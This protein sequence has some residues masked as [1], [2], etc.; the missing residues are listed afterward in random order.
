MSGVTKLEK[1]GGECSKRVSC[2]DNGASLTD[3]HTTVTHTD[4]QTYYRALRRR[5]CK[6]CIFLSSQKWLFPFVRDKSRGDSCKLRSKSTS[7][8]K[9]KRSRQ[10]AAQTQPRKKGIL[11]APIVVV[12]KYCVPRRRRRIFLFFAP[13]SLYQALAALLPYSFLLLVQ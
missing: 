11:K 3:R 10:E 4:R 6:P 2:G 1:G 8:E 12:L 13:F 9:G 7:G 5:K